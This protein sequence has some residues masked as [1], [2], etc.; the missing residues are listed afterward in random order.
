MYIVIFPGFVPRSAIAES[1]ANS[2]LDSLRSIQ[3]VFMFKTLFYDPELRSTG[4]VCLFSPHWTLVMGF[5][6][7]YHRIEVL[8]LSTHI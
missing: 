7:E 6:K 4:I 3:T 8:F 2:L 5:E 1:Y